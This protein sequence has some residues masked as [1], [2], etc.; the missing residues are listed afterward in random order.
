MMW[1]LHHW[2]LETGDSRQDSLRHR[3][4]AVLPNAP[5]VVVLPSI[6]EHYIVKTTV[7]IWLQV[8]LVK[9]HLND[10]GLRD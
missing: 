8:K 5:G 2:D 4:P 7:A 1:W 6:E 10:L 3:I 9:F